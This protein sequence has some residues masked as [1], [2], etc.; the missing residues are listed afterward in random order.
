MSQTFDIGSAPYCDSCKCRNTVKRASNSVNVKQQIQLVVRSME[1]VLVDTEEAVSDIR[2]LLKQIDDV[3]RRIEERGD[4][5]RIEGSSAEVASKSGRNI[6]A[7]LRA[8]HCDLGSNDSTKQVTRHSTCRMTSGGATFV[9]G[10]WRTRAR[11][12]ENAKRWFETSPSTPLAFEDTENYQGILLQ[13]HRPKLCSADVIEQ[14]QSPLSCISSNK[15]PRSKSVT[16]RD[17]VIEEEYLPKR[18]PSERTSLDYKKSAAGLSLT[19]F[20]NSTT[21]QPLTPDT[22]VSLDSAGR[23]PTSS[24]SPESSHAIDSDAASDG[25]TNERCCDEATNN[26][27]T[28]SITE[29]NLID[30]DAQMNNLCDLYST[31]STPGDEFGN[32]NK[33][34][35]TWKTYALLHVV[36]D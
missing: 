33:N 21:G 23:S 10:G 7:P 20:V 11:N 17:Y 4:L 3:T 1:M 36:E 8:S 12:I 18:C 27:K 9:R 15:L 25:F 26:F 30:F 6:S 19:P 32:Y 13:E 14:T 16:F 29:L 35:N 31:Y 22:P 5:A 2:C 28:D 24:Q 34:V